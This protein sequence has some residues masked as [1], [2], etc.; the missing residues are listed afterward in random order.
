[1]TETDAPQKSF[2]VGS[3]GMW[4]DSNSISLSVSENKNSFHACISWSLAAFFQD[5]GDLEIVLQG[6]SP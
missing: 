3:G 4:Q 5:L 6:E 2:R 1:M